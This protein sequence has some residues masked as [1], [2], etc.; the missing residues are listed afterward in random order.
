MKKKLNL[1][2]IMDCLVFSKPWAI[3][4]YDLKSRNNFKSVFRNNLQAMAPTSSIHFAPNGIS[5]SIVDAMR[6]VRMIRPS[7]VS[8][9][10][11]RH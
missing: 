11:L 1:R 10:T 9:K 3:V 2:L 8:G 7:N 5:T 4:D 6:V